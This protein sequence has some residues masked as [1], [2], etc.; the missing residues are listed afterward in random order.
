MLRSGFDRRFPGP[1]HYF[2]FGVVSYWILHLV[3][4]A[5]IPDRLHSREELLQEQAVYAFHLLE[6]RDAATLTYSQAWKLIVANNL[7]L[8]QA[9]NAL[10]QSREARQ[11]IFLDWLPSVNLSAGL[12]RALTDLGQV[13]SDDFRFNVFGAVNIPG[14]VNTR[15]RYL[16]AELAIIRAEWSLELKKRELA[17]RLRELFIRFENLARR[18][19]DLLENPLWLATE[20]RV[21]VADLQPEALERDNQLF[22]LRLERFSLQE[23]LSRLLGDYSQAWVLDG[24]DLPQINYYQSPLDLTQPLTYGVL[25]RRLQ[26]AEMEGL[27]LRRMG[28]SLG[29]W[30]DLSLNLSAPPL[31]SINQGQRQ[32]FAIDS[33]QANFNSSMRLDT[34]LRLRDQLRDVDRQIAIMNERMTQEIISQ[35]ERLRLAQEELDMIQRRLEHLEFRLQLLQSVP[36]AATVEGL[37]AQ[38]RNMVLLAE[39]RA[40]LALQ[41]AQTEAAFWLVDDPWWEKHLGTFSIDLEEEANE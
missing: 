30:P 31:F 26:A 4:C 2:V 29:Y 16:A 14:L 3:G 32:S 6:S 40:S 28:V 19:Q 27:R 9:R 13:S 10:E 23:S 34:Q 20:R 35:I 15:S 1:K 12:N 37:R 39:Q 18:E 11:R 36:A 17:I 33:V 5:T 38:L 41:K 22:G 8:Q 25:L 21:S 24:N 7:E